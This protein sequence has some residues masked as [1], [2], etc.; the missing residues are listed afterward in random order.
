M[1]R[2]RGRYCSRTEM[3][4]TLTES[5]YSSISMIVLPVGSRYLLIIGPPEGG[6]TMLARRLSRPGPRTTDKVAN[7]KRS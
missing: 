3:F 7:P 1:K 4:P 6:K 5:S 2:E